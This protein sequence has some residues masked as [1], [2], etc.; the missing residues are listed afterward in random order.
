MIIGLVLLAELAPRTEAQS[1]P[2]GIRLSTFSEDI[3]IPIG[4]RCMG[5]LPQKSIQIAD[6][7]EARGLVLRSDALPI[8]LVAL[9][10]CE[11]RNGSYEEWR[12]SLAEA[13]QTT[14]ER[15]LVASLHQHDAPVVDA[16]A[17][18][19]LEDVG[20]TDELFAK[21]FHQEALQ[22]VSDA[23]RKSLAQE[24]RVT[25]I[26]TS[27]AIVE[28]IASNRRMVSSNGTVQFSRGSSS[29]RDAVFSRR[30]GW[31]DRSSPANHFLLE[32]GSVSIGNAL[33][34]NA[35]DELLRQ[36]VV[37]ADFVGLARRLRQQETK[38]TFQ[39]YFSGCSG[40]VTAGKYNDG[41]PES[42]AGLIQRL[43]E[44]MVRSSD[45]VEKIPLTAMHFRKSSLRLDYASKAEL[46]ADVL[47]KQLKDASVKTETR[48]LAAMGLASRRRVEQGLAIDFP[49]VDLGATQV[50]LFPGES[51]V[52]FQLMAQRL[53]PNR[54]VFPIGYG[55]CWPG[56]VPTE[57]AFQDGFGDSWIWVAPGSEAKIEQSLREVLR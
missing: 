25:H 54:P 33:V 22:R 48:I 1:V 20:L 14:P 3:T 56:Y 11:V 29:G 49:C 32:R 38:K 52:G 13:A 15:V 41:T 34:R 21:G 5:I 6:P 10:W 53:S 50:V 39:I 27:H 28:N 23:V 47:Q 24:Q 44:A 40:D 18:K 4:H 17:A 46:A 7:L 36:R 42:R 19:L 35:P 8:V 51:F 9:D 12:R 37:S 43:H 30:R 2:S 57:K 55:E 26:G 16:D 45:A 31:G